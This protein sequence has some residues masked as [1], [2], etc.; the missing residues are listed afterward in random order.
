[1]LK[2]TF[3]RAQ[4]LVDYI[5]CVYQSIWLSRIWKVEVHFQKQKAK[6]NAGVIFV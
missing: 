4:K 2:Y 3:K 1:M 5:C 6:Q